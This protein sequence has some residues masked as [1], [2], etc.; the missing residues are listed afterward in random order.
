MCVYFLG[1]GVK[2]RPLKRLWTGRSRI[3]ATGIKLG[4]R[5]RGRW[6]ARRPDVDTFFSITH[7]RLENEMKVKFLTF[8]FCFLAT[9]FAYSQNTLQTESEPQEI[10]VTGS[11]VPIP[12][13]KTGPGVTVI[14]SRD[15]ETMK[16]NS[17]TD[18]LKTVPGVFITESG[19][20]GLANLK[21]RGGKNGMSMIMIDGVQ[22]FDATD[23]D[24]SL[25]ISSIPIENI[26]RIEIVKGP[27]SASIGSGAMN[28]AVNIITKKGSPKKAVNAQANFESSLWKQNSKGSA[29]LYG[30]NDKIN[31]RIGGASSYDE[32]VSAY[33]KGKEQDASSMGAAFAYVG[34]T[35]TDNFETSLTLNYVDKEDELDNVYIGGGNGTDD[36]NYTQRLRRVFAAWNT[37]YILNDFWEPS[38]KVFYTLQD[39]IYNNEPDS[40]SSASNHDRYVGQTTG[41]DFQ[42]NFYVM[43]EIT[44]TAGLFYQT[45][46]ADINSSYSSYGDLKK[47]LNK[48]AGYL[49]GTVNLFDAWTTIVAVRGDKYSDTALTPTGRIS[50]VYDIKAIDLQLKAAFGTGFNGPTLYQ[51]YAPNPYEPDK[52]YGNKDLKPQKSTSYEVGFTNGILN[53]MFTWGV[54]GFDN[55][56]RDLIVWD[57]KYYNKNKA[58]SRGIEAE[59][60]VFPC[61]YFNLKGFYVF[62]E[63]KDENGKIM[64]NTPSHQYRLSATMKPFEKFSLY[65]EVLFASGTGSS[66]ATTT[67][68]TLLNMAASYGITENIEIYLKGTNLTDLKYEVNPGYG[69]KGIEVYAGMTMKI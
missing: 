23:M 10:I 16:P 56:Y 24:N 11:R 12:V 20:G 5:G 48:Y 51:L 25:D 27:V 54:T 55:Y 13:S 64:Y 40:Q 52:P 57:N 34:L 1:N 9:S 41:A 32:G 31:Y 33:K 66:K 44:M 6:Q 49:Q 65:T 19:A 30:G 61:T 69:T 21:I 46:K 67:P 3:T 28:G 50:S 18:I 47:A 68:Y 15:I 58:H 38:L 26:E 37:K 43:D 17:V 29:S 53:R 59:F 45:D 14:T 7:L 42:N 62:T 39:R 60:G 22:V 8:V 36:P 4:R 35:P 2:L 63:T